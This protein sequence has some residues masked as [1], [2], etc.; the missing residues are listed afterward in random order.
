MPHIQYFDRS[1]RALS[2]REA[3]E[4]DGKTIR[5]GVRCR[6]PH[7]LADHAM[8]DAP[9][10]F[11]WDAHRASAS[12]TDGRRIVQGNSPGFRILADD[13]AGR[14]AVAD[15]RSAYVWD[16]ENAWRNPPPRDAV[17]DA[18][19]KADPP[20]TGRSRCPECDGS[21]VVHGKYCQGCGGDG[22][23]DDDNNGGNGKRP[24]LDPASD[25]RSINQIAHDHAVAME[26]V[27]SARNRE[28]SEAWRE[29]K[30]T[31]G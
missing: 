22:W 12:L 20:V 28:T 10:H 24:Q 3:F 8:R 1:G 15:A 2:R 30:V 17:G 19:K 9:P 4:A 6:V 31:N 27:Y 11:A 13:D 5:D 23:V 29:G 21:G 25:R 7:Q 26:Q 14:K 16:L 18:K